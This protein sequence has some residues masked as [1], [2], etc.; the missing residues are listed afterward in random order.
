ML[1]LSLKVPI[2]TVADDILILKPLFCWA[3]IC[4]AFANNADPDQSASSE[5]N[6]SGFALFVIKYVNLY[7]QS[8]SNNLIGW[9]SEVGIAS[10]A[11]QG[12]NNFS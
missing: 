2:T 1:N 11:C 9:K 4:P 3:R 6:W 8:G 7:Q 10:S 12:L 5:A